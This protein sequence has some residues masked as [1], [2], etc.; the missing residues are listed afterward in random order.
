MILASSGAIPHP[1][2][3]RYG[4]S[5]SSHQLLQPIEVPARPR[6]V[7]VRELRFGPSE[8]RTG[9]DLHSRDANRRTTTLAAYQRKQRDAEKEA[10]TIVEQANAE[11]ERLTAETTANL[12]E[13]LQ[14]RSAIALEKISQAEAQAVADVRDFAVDV[15]TSAARRVVTEQV[16]GDLADKLIDDSIAELSDKLH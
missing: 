7:R 8:G 6:L 1:V 11:A 2:P 12:E 5:A 13:E 15:A 14:R 3:T 10:E 9:G 16:K 4:S